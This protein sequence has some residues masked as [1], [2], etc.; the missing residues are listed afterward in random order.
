MAKLAYKIS[1]CLKYLQQLKNSWI[2]KG[3]LSKSSMDFC[4]I[5]FSTGSTHFYMVC[6]QQILL[7]CCIRNCW[8]EKKAFWFYE[9]SPLYQILDMKSLLLKDII[10]KNNPQTQHTLNKSRHAAP[11]MLL[12]PIPQSVSLSHKLH[13]CWQGGSMHQLHKSFWSHWEDMSSFIYPT[14]SVYRT[15]R[16]VAML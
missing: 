3:K 15:T 2:R 6:A 8:G 13:C 7:D 1:I 9:K 5:N 11:G 16:T 10:Q 4:R 12:R 14:I